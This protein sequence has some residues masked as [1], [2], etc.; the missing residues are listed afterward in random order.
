MLKT[1]FLASLLLLVP[2]LLSPNAKANDL[3]RYQLEAETTKGVPIAP[4]ASIPAGVQ[5]VLVVKV[6]DLRPNPSG[7]FSAHVDLSY[8]AT[9]IEQIGTFDRSTT[10]FPN[11]PRG[12][13]Y[14]NGSNIGIV[15]NVGG[16]GGLTFSNKAEHEVVRLTFRT[17]T[18][19]DHIRI[20]CARVPEIDQLLKPTL[21]YGLGVT[22]RLCEQE[23]HGLSLRYADYDFNRDKKCDLD[24]INA[25]LAAGDIS[26]GVDVNNK[27]Y[28]FDLDRSLVID[29]SDILEWLSLAAEE[30][31]LESA[32]LPGDANLDGVS[33]VSDFN[34][35]NA[36]KFTYAGLWNKG[37]FNGD[38]IVDV[39]D[40]N[41]WNSDKFQSS[42]IE[43]S[44]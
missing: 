13:H 23:Y 36:N 37:D 32:Y 26:Q 33:D 28:M 12:M 16:L 20:R 17:L 7:V 41:I 25:L 9:V 40:F 14:V 21:L 8:D 1:S 4:N 31:F 10:D 35:W 19:T 42:E 15:E 30:N 44:N 43:C 38:G 6:V 11:V 5:F 39:S 3:V 18:K 29:N 27:N 24:D 34:I 2:I 22:T